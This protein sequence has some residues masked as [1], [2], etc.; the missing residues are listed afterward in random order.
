MVSNNHK[1]Y[2]KYEGGHRK[3]I[4]KISLLTVIIAM[5]GCQPPDPI[6][7]KPSIDSQ[8]ATDLPIVI[9]E[10]TVTMSPEH[11]LSIKPSRYQPSLGLRGNIATIKQVRFKANQ[12]LTVQQVLVEPNQWVEAGTPLFIVKRQDIT[13]PAETIAD[14]SSSNDSDTNIKSD[15][16]SGINV[17]KDSTATANAKTTANTGTDGSS[18]AKTA[19]A[20]NNPTT[21]PDITTATA[22]TTLENTVNESKDKSPSRPKM[23]TPSLITIKAPFTGRVD[24]LSIQAMQQLDINTPMLSLSNNNDLHFVATLPIQAKPRLS[25]GQT[26]N[27]TTASLSDTF[28]GQVS[29]LTVSTDDKLL[30]DVHVIN[31]DNNRGK[32]KANMAVSGRVDYGQIEVGTIVPKSAIHDAD[33]SALSKAPFRPMVTLT[34]NVWIIQQNQRLTRQ[35]VEVIEY[36]PDT[37]RYLIAGINN[38]SLICLAQLPLQ[39][40]GKKVIVS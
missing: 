31:T 22:D 23:D 40:A 8:P 39:S 24:T 35:P 36:D 33:L 38:D 15:S 37:D 32:L 2:Y 11:I 14:N 9:D 27:F 12:A 30:V 28:T 13:T 21:K 26:V 5:T 16:D 20:P 6:V 7:K 34:A 10:N 25:V 1:K 3:A 4:L 29:K 17:K 18:A 19:T